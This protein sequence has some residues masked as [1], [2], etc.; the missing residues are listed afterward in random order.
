MKGFFQR[1]FFVLKG[2]KPWLD[3]G[4]EHNSNTKKTLSKKIFIDFGNQDQIYK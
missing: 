3:D 2:G 4:Q 1:L